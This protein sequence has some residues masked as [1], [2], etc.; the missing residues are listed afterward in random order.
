MQLGIVAIPG[1]PQ[2][3]GPG[4]VVERIVDFGRRV[5]RLGFAGCWIVDAFA[6]GQATL[7]PLMVLSTLGSV[8]GRIELGT[9]VMQ[10]PLRHPVELAP[11]V[12]ASDSRKWTA[13][14]V[15]CSS[16]FRRRH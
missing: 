10:V 3:G 16:E 5:E 8:T 1:A 9:C 11:L 7:D 12:I 6:R 2:T 4:A 13:E 15:T 14:L